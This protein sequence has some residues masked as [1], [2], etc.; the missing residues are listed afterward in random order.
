M[1]FLLLAAVVAAAGAAG[2]TLGRRDRGAKSPQRGAASTSVTGATM[3]STS[4][5][6]EV[7]R[8]GEST[9]DLSTLA[10]AL[11]DVVQYESDERWLAGCLVA[12]DRGEV[13]GGLFFAPE[14]KKHEVVAAFPA[15]RR[16]VFWMSPEPFECRCGAAGCR[17]TISPEDALALRDSWAETFEAALAVAPSVAQPLSPFFP[18]EGMPELLTLRGR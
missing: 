16:E 10:V 11:G 13:I 9:A 6:D 17:G 5:D 3:S 2:F 14:G 15:P 1:S 4:E 12:R 7:N 8:K 18:A